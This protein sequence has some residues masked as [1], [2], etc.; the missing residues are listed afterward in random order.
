M[1]RVDFDSISAVARIY[2]RRRWRPVK[3]QTPKIT[4]AIRKSKGP[5]GGALRDARTP[6]TPQRNPKIAS[7][8]GVTPPLAW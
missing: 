3:P 5:S 2:L 7:H 1:V 8:L 6:E 4:T